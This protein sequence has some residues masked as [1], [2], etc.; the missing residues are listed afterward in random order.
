[1]IVRPGVTITVDN[2]SELKNDWYLKGS[3]KKVGE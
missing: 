2:D 3:D 1:L